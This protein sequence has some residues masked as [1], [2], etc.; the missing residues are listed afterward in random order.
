M[1][2]ND[3]FSYCR[4]GG[5]QEPDSAEYRKRKD[6]YEDKFVK[7][8]STETDKARAAEEVNRKNSYQ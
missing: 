1:T 8:C 6:E 5:E 3:A 4:Y 7:R 2:V